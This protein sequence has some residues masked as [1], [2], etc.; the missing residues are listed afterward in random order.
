MRV[1]SVQLSAHLILSSFE[2]YESHGDCSH[3]SHCTEAKTN[4]RELVLHT[5][6]PLPGGVKG[7]NK[8]IVFM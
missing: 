6:G 2:T 3:E 4:V 8:L 5:A 1:M 7:W